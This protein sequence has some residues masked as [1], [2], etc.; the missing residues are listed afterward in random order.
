[1]VWAVLVSFTAS[2]HAVVAGKSMEYDSDIREKAQAV[3]KCS[4]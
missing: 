3:G 2:G 1:M 4:L